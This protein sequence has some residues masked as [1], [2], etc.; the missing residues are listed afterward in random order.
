MKDRAETAAGARARGGSSDRLLPARAEAPAL[1][2]FPLLP[3]LAQSQL[4]R[5]PLLDSCLRVRISQ[6]LLAGGVVCLYR[7]LSKQ[8]VKITVLNRQFCYTC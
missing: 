6:P 4:E 1:S 3:G 8:S 5:L 7:V 2:P